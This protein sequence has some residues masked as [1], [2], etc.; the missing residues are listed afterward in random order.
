M[1]GDEVRVDGKPK[2]PKTLL[3]ILTP[4]RHIP[5][6]RASFEQLGSP[7]VVDEHIDVAVLGSDLLR[8]ALHLAQRRGDRP[9]SLCLC[10]R[11]G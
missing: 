10:R 9:S 7:D 3:Q 5:V 1:G 6:A 4:E 11:A 8:Q 2:D